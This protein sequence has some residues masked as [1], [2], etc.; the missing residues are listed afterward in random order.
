MRE[1]E[2]YMQELTTDI[3]DMIQDASPEEKLMLQ[4]K[5]STLATKIK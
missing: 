5:I 1:L 2:A 4:Q 3:T